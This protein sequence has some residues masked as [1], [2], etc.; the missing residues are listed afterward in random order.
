MP[1]FG[2][3]IGRPDDIIFTKND[4]HTEIIRGEEWITLDV[5]DI[6]QTNVPDSIYSTLVKI[7]GRHI[8]DSIFGWRYLRA[9]SL[10]AVQEYVWN[11]AIVLDDGTVDVYE[12]SVSTTNWAISRV[13]PWIMAFESNTLFFNPGTNPEFY[14]YKPTTH[15]IVVVRDDEINCHFEIGSMTGIS[16]DL[17]FQYELKVTK[18]SSTTTED[19]LKINLSDGNILETTYAINPGLYMSPWL[20]IGPGMTRVIETKPKDLVA[21][22]IDGLFF[23]EITRIDYTNGK[24]GYVERQTVDGFKKEQ[25]GINGSS[26][27][28]MLSGIIRPT[29]VHYGNFYINYANVGR[30]CRGAVSSILGLPPSNSNVILESLKTKAAYEP[31]KTQPLMLYAVGTT[32]VLPDDRSKDTYQT[33][34]DPIIGCTNPTFTDRFVNSSSDFVGYC[35]SRPSSY[36]SNL[37]GSAGD[38]TEIPS[39]GQFPKHS[40]KGQG[41]LLD[42]YTNGDLRDI[43][44]LQRLPFFKTDIYKSNPLYSCL[45]PWRW[46]IQRNEWSHLYNIEAFGYCPAKITQKMISD[47]KSNF[48]VNYS[49]SDS[50][51]PDPDLID[52]NTDLAEGSIGKAAP[53]QIRETANPVFA[54]EKPITFSFPSLTQESFSSDYIENNTLTFWKM[55]KNV[56]PAPINTLYRI[57][58]YC[59]KDYTSY[60]AMRCIRPM[61][62]PFAS[63]TNNISTLQT[64]FLIGAHKADTGLYTKNERLRHSH[65]F[66][67]N[68][69]GKSGMTIST[70]L[71]LSDQFA[72]IDSIV[73]VMIYYDDEK[74]FTFLQTLFSGPQP[75]VTRLSDLHKPGVINPANAR[76]NSFSQLG[77]DYI[78]GGGQRWEFNLFCSTVNRNIPHSI[79]SME[80]P[81]NVTRTTLYVGANN[82]NNQYALQ[83]DRS[84][85]DG[86][87]NCRKYDADFSSGE[88]PT[89]YRTRTDSFGTGPGFGDIT[90]DEF[91]PLTISKPLLSDG[92]PAPFPKWSGLQ[93]PANFNSADGIKAGLFLYRSAFM[94]PADTITMPGAPGPVPNGGLIVPQL[95]TAFATCGINTAIYL[96]ES[97]TTKRRFIAMTFTDSPDLRLANFVGQATASYP[98]GP[99][100]T[101]VFPSDKN[102]FLQDPGNEVV[103]GHLG[104]KTSLDVNSVDNVASYHSDIPLLTM[105][106]GNI[107]RKQFPARSSSIG[108]YSDNLLWRDNYEPSLSNGFHSHLFK[109]TIGMGITYSLGDEEDTD[110]NAYTSLVHLFNYVEETKTKGPNLLAGDERS[111]YLFSCSN[112][113]ICPSR[114]ATNDPLYAALPR[115][116]YPPYEPSLGNWTITHPLNIL[117]V[118]DTFTDYPGLS[119]QRAGVYDIEGIHPYLFEIGLNQELHEPVGNRVNFELEERFH[120][121]AL[122]NER[123]S[124]QSTI[125]VELLETS[126]CSITGFKRVAIGVGTTSR[127][128]LHKETNFD[129]FGNLL[130]S[131]YTLITTFE[132]QDHF[133]NYYKIFPSAS[134]SGNSSFGRGIDKLHYRFVLERLNLSLE[135]FSSLY[136]I[137]RFSIS[138]GDST[139]SRPAHENGERRLL[140]SIF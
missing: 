30:N 117:A 126:A 43:E 28:S 59:H 106:K 110:G 74:Y 57:P 127:E 68:L 46:I 135:N 52:I 33:P 72:E 47:M 63:I 56:K 93:L 77:P 13:L 92:T 17:R 73:P 51:L 70:T 97:P 24:N 104:P 18:L 84:T 136:G 32:V 115:K 114:S 27:G 140:P 118:K 124:N 36:F 125:Y 66:L 29:D 88:V 45:S 40:I 2:L 16:L 113:M 137:V 35:I 31:G 121:G 12:L 131:T 41:F 98:D 64:N 44:I 14:A 96:E 9:D 134:S 50:F 102:Y 1:S 38:P 130:F 132:I 71:N 48:K 94:H 83:S 23:D 11:C 91:A 67:R 19:R 15:A 122:S 58:V 75:Y 99:I 8:S 10:T 3:S 112:R 26:N 55:D 42:K 89:T 76:F 25:Y 54:S 138:S 62:C 105:T 109:G 78:P 101:P 95:D 21:D 107:N 60:N 86:T 53:Y 116:M 7:G 85:S 103:F 119:Q 61:Y 22:Q 90:T 87:I 120:V 79:I 82:Y 37:S 65:A 6:N 129:D 108:M 133:L 80:A 49:F 123:S 20:E 5:D 4:V 69:T 111:H 100:V 34:R 139:N 81:A 128:D 39:E